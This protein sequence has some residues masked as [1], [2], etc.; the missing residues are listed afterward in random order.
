MAEMFGSHMPKIEERTAEFHTEAHVTAQYS[1]DGVSYGVPTL[2]AEIG[3]VGEIDC[4][5][6]PGFNIWVRD[7]NGVIPFLGAK[8]QGDPAYRGEVFTAS[9]TGKATL[10][11]FTP[12]AMTVRVENATRG[13]LVVLNQNW[14]SGW[15]GN[16]QPA[17]DYHDLVAAPVAGPYQTVVF[18]YLPRLWWLSLGIL[19]VTV[20]A[21]VAA[22]VLRRRERARLLRRPRPS[23]APSR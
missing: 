15:R 4:M 11:R 6:F 19:A 9:G 10:E 12:N 23:A 20:G 17:V 5:I 22:F 3:N 7:S 14:D 8:G 16:G 1:Y 21:I 13:D 18:R 2:P